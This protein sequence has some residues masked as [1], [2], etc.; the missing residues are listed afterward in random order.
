M[1]IPKFERFQKEV[2]FLVI[3]EYSYLRWKIILNTEIFYFSWFFKSWF[4]MLLESRTILSF[5]SD[6]SPNFGSR[7]IVLSGCKSLGWCTIISV[8]FDAFH[9]SGWLIEVGVVV[10][11]I[12]HG[13]WAMGWFGSYTTDII[14]NVVGTWWLVVPIYVKMYGLYTP[15]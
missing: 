6:K 11:I 10:E 13:G 12:H 3:L 14:V 15:E 5:A 7:S 9:W 8:C 4:F 2:K 1:N